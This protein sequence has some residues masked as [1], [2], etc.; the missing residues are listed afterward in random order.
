MRKIQIELSDDEAL[1]LFERLAQL[2]DQNALPA[3]DHAEELVFWNV[4]GQLERRLVAPLKPNYKELVEE[5]K[6]RVTMKEYDTE[7]SD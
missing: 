3:Q 4:Q 6:T 2:D 7:Q 1:I 5:A